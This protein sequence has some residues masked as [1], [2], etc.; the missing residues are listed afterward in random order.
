MFADA[1]L[2]ARSPGPDVQSD[3][4]LDEF[5]DVF[6]LC[7][8][9]QTHHSDKKPSHLSAALRGRLQV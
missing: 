5:V 4:E 8:A 2:P 3:A 9:S 7:E 1:G 6:V